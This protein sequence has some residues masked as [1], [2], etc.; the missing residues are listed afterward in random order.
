M[1]LIRYDIENPGILPEGFTPSHISGSWA[2]ASIDERNPVFNNIN[3][4]DVDQYEYECEPQRIFLEA[5]AAGYDTGLG[6]TIGITDADRSQFTQ[7]LVIFQTASAPDDTDVS[8]A[9]ITG[10]LHQVTLADFRT[11]MVAAGL[12]YQT[13][14]T[15]YKTAIAAS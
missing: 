1:K 4:V 5:V 14:W 3:Y 2:Y 9:D 6:Y 13:L 11:L 8:I 10:Q 7:L 15:N 12:Y